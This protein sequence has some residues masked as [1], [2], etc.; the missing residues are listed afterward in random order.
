MNRQGKI[1]QTAR[2]RL[3]QRLRAERAVRNI[4]QEQLAGLAGMHRTY[5][6]SIERG[7]RN[8]G[9]DNIELLADVLGLDI[10]VLLA[11]N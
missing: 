3:A 8:V 1:R 2:Q 10:S 11:P 6:G 7:E 5:V 9:L 4:S